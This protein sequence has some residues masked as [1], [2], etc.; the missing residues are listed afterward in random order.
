MVVYPASKIPLHE[1]GFGG[2]GLI[3]VVRMKGIAFVVW[4]KC[5]SVGRSDSVDFSRYRVLL[6]I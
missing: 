1:I 3:R 4:I 6:S 5:N 2:C